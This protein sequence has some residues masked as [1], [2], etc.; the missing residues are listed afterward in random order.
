[1]LLPPKISLIL[2][3][4][5]VCL[6]IVG[7]TAH[8]LVLVKAGQICAA[9]GIVCFSL[10]A[11]WLLLQPES[12]TPNAGLLTYVRAFFT[13]WLSGMSGP[14]SVPFAALAV[15]SEQGRQKIIWACLAVAAA[16]LGSYRVW[17]REHLAGHAVIAELQREIAHLSQTVDRLSAQDGTEEVWAELVGEG[18]KQ[19]NVQLKAA[20]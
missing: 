20:C 6:I 13:D 17:Q 9:A 1:M 3:A 18:G 16:L 8:V 12:R 19:Y 5:A 7:D 10:Y 2:G 4:L 11:I 15:W 14:L